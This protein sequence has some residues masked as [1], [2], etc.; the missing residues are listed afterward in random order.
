MSDVHKN[1][2]LDLGYLLREKAWKPGNQ[3]ALLKVLITK[4]INWDGRWLITR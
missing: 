3:L 2:L 1:C 4:L